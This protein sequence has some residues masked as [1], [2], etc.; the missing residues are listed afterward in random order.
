[1]NQLVSV[2]CVVLTFC[3]L[4][5]LCASCEEDKKM[6]P[7]VDYIAKVNSEIISTEEFQKALDEIKQAGKGFFANNESASRIKR[8]LLERLIDQKLLLQEARKKHI[9]LDPALVDASMKM[10][11]DEYPDGG[12]EQQLKSKGMSDAE[13]AKK[14]K[15]SQLIQKLLKQ[16]VVDRVAVSSDDISN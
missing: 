6:E 13:Y 12:I 2:S 16:E 10:L 15:Q 11:K 7:K 8:D 3:L 9:I 5:S 14:T 1:V 4:G